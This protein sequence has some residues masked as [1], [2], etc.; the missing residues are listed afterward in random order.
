MNKI[1][2][3]LIVLSL[4]ASCTHSKKSQEL[5]SCRVND[6]ND[7]H[8][9]ESCFDGG[10]TDGTLKL[11]PEILARINFNVN[12][13]WVTYSDSS[14][15]QPGNAVHSSF[16]MGYI[17]PN[18][19]VHDVVFFDNGPDYF[20]EGLARYIST[21]GKTGFINEDLQEILPAIHDFVAPFRDGKAVFCDGCSVKGEGEHP[22]VT[23]GLWGI[24]NKKGKT[25]KGPMEKKLFESE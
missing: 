5:I 18:G 6:F 2:I 15:I 19:K 20:K 1:S 4:F 10:N 24:M 23:G 9:Y 21:N 7:Y 25:L 16:V 8:E 14:R 12:K 17:L 22:E 3:S 11:K 13:K